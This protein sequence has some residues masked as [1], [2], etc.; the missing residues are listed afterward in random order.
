MPIQRAKPRLV[1]LDQTPLTSITAANLP[2]GAILQHLQS[3]TIAEVVHSSNQGSWI[4]SNYTLAITPSATS[5][6]VLIH[7]HMPFALKNTGVKL[8]GSM[9]LN[10]AIS[11]GSTTLIWNTD[12]YLEQFHTRDAGG[13]P[14][15]SN[16]LGNMTFIDSPNTTSATTYTMQIIIKNDSGATHILSHRSSYGGNVILQEI[17]G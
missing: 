17:K 7:M 3:G 15:E 11:G 9:R 16:V 8:R 14:D 2:A 5:S 4:D 10:R 1:D 6:R 12:S 13:T